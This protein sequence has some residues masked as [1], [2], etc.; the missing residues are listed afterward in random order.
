MTSLGS[1]LI[2]LGA[3]GLFFYMMKNGGGCCGGHNHNKN[4]DSN[5][6]KT[7]KDPVCGMEVSCTT[8]LR[9]KNNGTNYYFCSPN[10]LEQFRRKPEAYAKNEVKKEQ[11]T[12]GCCH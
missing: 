10:C 5:S 4:H 1:I 7:E 11:H 6:E 8:D 2:G 9:Q 3:F 12:G